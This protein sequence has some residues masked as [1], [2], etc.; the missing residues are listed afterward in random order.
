MATTKLYVPYSFS[1]K[2]TQE[3]TVGLLKYI[4]G[5]SGALGSS[6]MEMLADVLAWYEMWINPE[7]V[8]WKYEFIQSTRPSAGSMVTFHY[9]RKNITMSVSGTTGWI[10]NPSADSSGQY[11]DM[12]QSLLQGGN[13]MD[14]VKNA[15]RG[16]GHD[17][18]IPGVADDPTIAKNMSRPYGASRTKNAQNNSARKF[19]TRLRDLADEPMYYT[20]LYGV[21][22]YNVKYIKIYTKQFPK[23]VM[24]EGYFT[25]FVI[26]ESKDD[27]Q[28]IN[29][30]F[31][32]M[33]EN[34]TPISQAQS[35][36]GKYAGQ[37]SGTGSALRGASGLF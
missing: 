14:A 23:G 13:I 15:A 17:L 29:Y 36:L 10:L 26:P 1:S 35:V 20:D 18:N 34:F 28:T 8:D 7:K 16:L 32:F 31:T 5:M 3:R 9:R 4:P 37:M 11:E 21:E 30:S 33:V 12:T 24:C 27:M 2:R 6:T 25:D 22:H 19:L